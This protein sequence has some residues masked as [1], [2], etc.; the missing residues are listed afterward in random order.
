MVRLASIDHKGSTKLVA[1]CENDNDGAFYVDLTKIASTTRPFLEKGQDAI[2][3]ANEI[4][5]KEST[6]KIPAAET[7]LLVPLDPATCG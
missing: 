6:P 3:Q 1:Q 4:L 5:A 7:R 2:A